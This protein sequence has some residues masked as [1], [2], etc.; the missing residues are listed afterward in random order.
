LNNVHRLTVISSLVFSAVGISSPLMTL[1]LQALGAGF[2]RISLILTSVAATLMV[3]NYIWGRVSDRLG[4]RKPLIIGGLASMALMFT[5]LSRA[6]NVNW[7]W[8]VRLLEGL[9][10]AAYATTSLALMGDLISARGKRG[11]RMGFYRGIGSFSFAVGAVI[12]GRLADQFSISFALSVSAGLYLTASLVALTLSEPSPRSK[13][14]NVSKPKVAVTSTELPQANQRLP[15]LFL[16]GVLMW[17]TALGASAS[18]WPNF[19][20]SLGYNKT[21]ISSLWGLAATVEAIG[22]P[23]VG[24]LSDVVGRAPLLAAGGLGIAIVMLGYIILARFL[25]ALIG[26]QIVRGFGYSSYTASAMTFAAELGDERV[27]GNNT[28]L[29]NATTSSGQLLGSFLGGTIVEVMGFEF[30]F[31]V[32]AVSALIS[33]FF[34][35]VLRYRQTLVP[36]A[37]PG[38]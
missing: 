27:R 29:F 7:A 1:Y 24:N 20:A 9:S 38:R 37:E 36:V 3:S 13:E 2:A 31:G 23:L 30:L 15:L 25:P 18:M 34:F 6:P 12:G 14:T 35:L 16:A 33:A 32:C 19:M 22:M 8:G 21:T 5:L 28:G 4:R 11:R 10:M 17:V 26:V